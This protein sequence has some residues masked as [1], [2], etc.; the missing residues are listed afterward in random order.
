MDKKPKIG[1]WK[2]GLSIAWRA[3]LMQRFGADSLPHREAD[4][5]PLRSYCFDRECDERGSF[6]QSVRDHRIYFIAP[7]GGLPSD[8]ELHRE[9]AGAFDLE[10]LRLATLPKELAEPQDKARCR[11]QV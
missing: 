5:R 1:G 9:Q 4:E 2:F 6:K 11:Y 8:V 10:N 7:F 3:K